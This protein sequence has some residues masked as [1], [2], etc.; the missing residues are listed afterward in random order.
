M[1]IKWSQLMADTNKVSTERRNM[2]PNRIRTMEVF[3]LAND[4]T[5]V[6][7]TLRST[8]NVTQPR[9][10]SSAKAKKKIATQSPWKKDQLK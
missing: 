7:V 4:A 1:L 9:E 6:F 3:N 5:E 10:I 2:G 8:R